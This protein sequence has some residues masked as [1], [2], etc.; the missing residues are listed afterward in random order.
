[1]EEAK[2]EINKLSYSKQYKKERI[3]IKQEQIDVIVGCVEPKLKKRITVNQIR[4]IVPSIHNTVAVF[5]WPGGPHDFINVSQDMTDFMFG[6]LSMVIK[7][8]IVNNLVAFQHDLCKLY[9]T[10]Y[11]SLSPKKIAKKQND[12]LKQFKKV[13]NERHPDTTT[14][15]LNAKRGFGQKFE[16]EVA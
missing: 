11:T 14:T 3:R 8:N 12:D 15:I 9:T 16:F 2:L 4:K 6:R 13:F 1:M 7:G 10:V 5:Y